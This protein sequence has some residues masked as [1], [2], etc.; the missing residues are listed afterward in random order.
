M[1]TNTNNDEQEMSELR[2][3]DEQKSMS[4]L[5]HKI[6]AIARRNSEGEVTIHMQGTVTEWITSDVAFDR[7]DR[8]K[9]TENRIETALNQ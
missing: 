7:R 8:G 9:M 6:R 2:L 1:T 5:Q 3:Q 4:D